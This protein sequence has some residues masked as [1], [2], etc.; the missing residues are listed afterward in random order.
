[1]ETEPRGVAEAKQ[2]Y[3][4]VHNLASTSITGPDEA[5]TTRSLQKL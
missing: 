3:E 5:K 4:S 2:E 1:M